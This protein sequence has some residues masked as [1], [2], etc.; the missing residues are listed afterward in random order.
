MFYVYL[1]RSMSQPD[2]TYVGYTSRAPTQRLQEHNDGLTIT[3]YRHR[4]WRIEVVVGFYNRQKAEE[5]E[6]YL[7]HGSGHAFARKHFWS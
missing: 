4:P 6:R 1:L 5:F 3:T 2:M 7:K